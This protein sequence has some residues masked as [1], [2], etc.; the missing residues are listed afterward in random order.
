MYQFITQLI[1]TQIICWYKGLI[2]K[3]SLAGIIWFV[4][5]RYIFLYVLRV[6]RVEINDSLKAPIAS[7]LYIIYD[8]YQRNIYILQC[9]LR[10]ITR[11]GMWKEFFRRS[12][13]RCCGQN[14]LCS[15]TRTYPAPS[16]T[17]LANSIFRRW[18]FGSFGRAR[19]KKNNERGERTGDNEW[20]WLTCC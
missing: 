11:Y 13:A 4:C 12:R 3:T 10:I 5:S 14:D 6:H 15:I 8:I 18:V 17:Y 19:K 1:R 2:A 16:A 7:V 20:L 9:A